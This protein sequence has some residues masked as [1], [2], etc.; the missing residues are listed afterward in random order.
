[1]VPA[2]RVEPLLAVAVLLA[3]LLDPRRVDRGPTLCLVRRLTGHRC[4]GCGM[5]RSWTLCAHLRLAPAF[6]AHP[7]G[8]PTFALALVALLRASAGPVGRRP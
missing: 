4:P 3:L 1:M 7:L 5:T 2:T 6:R 8:P